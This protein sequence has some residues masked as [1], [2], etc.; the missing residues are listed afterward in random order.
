M[1]EQYFSTVQL[2]RPL[3]LAI[4]VFLGFEYFHVIECYCLSI[5]AVFITIE[6]FS[7][8]KIEETI[9]SGSIFAYIFLY[10]FFLICLP[11]PKINPKPEVLH[12]VGKL[13]T[14]LNKCTSQNFEFGPQEPE[15]S[16]PK[17]IWQKV[18]KNMGGQTCLYPA[19]PSF[20]GQKW[21]KNY[22]FTEHFQF[23]V[24]SLYYISRLP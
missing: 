13:I 1:T 5:S 12:I 21:K 18:D 11:W 3:V 9:K 4:V 15:I 20:L 17:K 19:N 8:I 23:L 7:D 24:E 6:A 14:F 2:L 16:P 10:Y 22:F